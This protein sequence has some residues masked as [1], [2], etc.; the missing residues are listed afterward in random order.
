MSGETIR[1]DTRKS[2]KRI[3]RL[4]EQVKRIPEGRALLAEI[5]DLCGYGKTIFCRECERQNNFNQGKQF[6]ANWLHEKHDK[7][8]QEPEGAIDEN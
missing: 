7:Y 5:D 1:A 3:G 6:V 4:I 2:A 8:T